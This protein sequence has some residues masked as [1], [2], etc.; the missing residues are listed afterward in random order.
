MRHVYVYF[1]VDLTQA[2]LAGDQIDSLLRAMARYCGQPPHRMHRC[3]DPA[4]WM[5][6]YPDIADIEG[7]SM[8]LRATVH[9]LDCTRFILGERH[10][11]CFVPPIRD[12]GF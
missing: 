11:E 3:D 12:L 10:L 4:T 7:F 6:S 2:D 1:Q 9:N 5:E 8:A